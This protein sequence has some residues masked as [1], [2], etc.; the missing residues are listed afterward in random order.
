M[1]A[2]GSPVLATWWSSGLRMRNSN[3]KNNLLNLKIEI[4]FR[5]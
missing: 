1:V 2:D 5:N 4:I 3:S